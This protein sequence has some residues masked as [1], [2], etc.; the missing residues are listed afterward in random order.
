M[1]LTW[2]AER[3]PARHH[4][5]RSEEADVVGQRQL[6][7][8]HDLHP[9]PRQ[10]GDDLALVLQVR[11]AA[12]QARLGEEGGPVVAAQARGARRQPLAD[13]PRHPDKGGVRRGAG[14][15]GRAHHRQPREAHR[16]VD[17]E[18]VLGGEPHGAQGG[19][20]ERG[21]EPGGGRPVGMHHQPGGGRHAIGP[22]PQPR[23]RLDQKVAEVHD[24]AAGVDVGEPVGRGLGHVGPAG[25]AFRDLAQGRQRVAAALHRQR[26]GGVGA[27]EHAPAPVLHMRG[28]VH[29]GIGFDRGV[30]GDDL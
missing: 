28:G 26:N 21:G 18:D 5:A 7:R 19:A 4:P 23:Q 29:V 9:P 13:A 2:W 12:D 25:G 3:D 6:L 22:R 17:I 8:V 1:R 10:L 30:G 24:V 11:H 15:E 16:P 14:Q 20:R 27:V